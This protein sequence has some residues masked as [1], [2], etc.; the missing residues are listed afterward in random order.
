[1]TLTDVTSSAQVPLA[2]IPECEAEMRIIRCVTISFGTTEACG[3]RQE[4]LEEDT[5]GARQWQNPWVV[6]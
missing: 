3:A 2:M 4:Q 5:C 1:M 6:P